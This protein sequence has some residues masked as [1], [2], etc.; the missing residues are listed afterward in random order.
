MPVARSASAE[1]LDAF[2]DPASAGPGPTERDV[3]V[4]L[5]NGNVIRRRYDLAGRLRLELRPDGTW[6][7]YRYDSEGHPR[8]VEHSS[9]ERVDYAVLD[10]GRT[11]RA[12]SAAACTTVQ[13][14]DDGMP[15]AVEQVID[16]VVL[17][18]EYERDERGQVRAWRYPEGNEWLRLVPEG[19][20]RLGLR[21]GDV[22]Y[23]TVEGL[24]DRSSAT[25]AW[26]NGA[27]TVEEMDG[28]APDRVSRIAV[29]GNG[30]AWL[31]SEAEYDTEGRLRR[32]EGEVV[33][34]DEEGR[35][36]RCGEHWFAYDERGRLVRRS[37][38]AGATT[39]G[40]DEQPMVAERHDPDGSV[41]FR[42][43]ALGRRIATES[44]AGVTTYRYDLF[45]QLTEVHLTDG[46]SIRY[47]YDGFGRLVG[48]D[49]GDTVRCWLVGVDG[50]R[51]AEADR[52]GA[53]VASW[54]WIGESCGARID[55]P[56][57]KPIS[58]TYH[59]GVDGR[60]IATA[61]EDGRLVEHD[62]LDPFGHGAVPDGAPGFDG[63]FGDA[64][65]GLVLA[66]T[67]WLDPSVAQMLTPDPWFG[68]DAASR[69]PAA[70][71][72]VV[73]TLP[74][75]TAVELTP[76]A[77][78]AWCGYDPLART[79]PNGHNWLGLIFSTIS[80]LLWEM[81]LTSLSLQIQVVNLIAEVIQLVILR[82]VWDSS[83]YW[84]HSIFNMAAPMASYR[85]M[86]PFA[87]PLNGLLRFNDRGYTIGSVIWVRGDKWGDLASESQRTLLHC[88]E[89]S[90]FTAARTEAAADVFRARNPNAVLSGT[91][92]ASDQR[93]IDGASV[94]NP[95][96]ATTAQV[97]DTGD[98]VAVAPAGATADQPPD[99]LRSVSSVAASSILVDPALPASMGGQAVE[100]RRLDPA[101]V[102]LVRSQK[103]LA[104]TVTFVRG[105]AVHFRNQVAGDFF[106]GE[107]LEVTELL[108]AGRRNAVTASLPIEHPLLR[109]PSAGD[110][111][112]FSAGDVVRIE[113]AGT[114]AARTIAGPG[115][116]GELVLDSPLP[117]GSYTN[118]AV[119]RL[120]PSG[121]AATGQSATGARVTLGP[122]FALVRRDGLAIENTGGSPVTTERGIAAEVVLDLTVDAL[123]TD[124]HGATGSAELLDLDVSVRASATVSGPS[125][126]AASGAGI[127]SLAAGDPVNIQPSS[128]G[129]AVGVLAM[130]DAAA[131]T[132]T[133]VDPL[134]A[135][136]AAGTA[137]TV[138][139]LGG[140]GASGTFTT[141]TIAAPG[142]HVLVR[143]PESAVVA[144][145]RALRIRR[146]GVTTGGAVRLVSAAPQ[147][148]ADLD[149][150]VPA[151]HT[152]NL[153]VT[154]LAP[155]P[156]ASR[157]G[158][159]APAV[160]LRLVTTSPAPFTV[161]DVLHLAD[162]TN[163]A[164]RG[165]EAVAEVASVSG[166]TVTLT[167]PVDAPV[168]TS[169][170]A[171]VVVATGG[172]S[173]SGRLGEGKVLV[174]SDLSVEPRTRREAFEDHEMRH[175]WQGAV[176]GPFLVS[177]PIPWLVNLGFSFSSIASSAS[178]IVR[179]CGMGGLDSL[180]AALVWWIGGAEGATK[181]DG[182]LDTDRRS[183]R[184]DEDAP[185]P[186]VAEF[187]EG[188]RID[189]VKGD[190]AAV[191]NVVDSASAGA[192][193]LRFAL[194]DGFSGGDRVQLTVEPYEQVRKTIS[195][196]FSLNLEQLW[197]DHIPTSWGRALSNLLNRDAWFPLIGIYPLSLLVAGFNED[198]LPNE[199]DAAYH[200]GDLYTTIVTSTPAS[201]FVGQF[202][203][204]YAFIHAR[205]GFLSSRGPLSQLSVMLP[206]G[207]T[208]ADVAGSVPIGS[209]SV[210]FRERWLLPMHDEAEN[211]VGALFAA[212]APG[213]YQLR[214][215]GDLP[216]G[217]DIVFKFAYDVSFLDTAAVEVRALELQP[218]PAR[219][220]L[221]T[222]QVTFAVTGDPSA[223]YALAV[224]PGA[225]PLA[226][227]LSGLRYTAPVLT[228]TSP[229][230]ETV[231]V[232]AT[233]RADH[234]V[235][236]GPGQSTAAN[237][238]PE[239]RTNRCQTVTLRV[240]PIVL[241]SVAAVAAGASSEITLPIAP[242]AASIRPLPAGA[243]PPATVTVLAG[244]PPRIRF[245][246]PPAVASPV[247][248]EIELV[249]GADPAVRKTMVLVVRVTA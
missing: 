101:V 163:V 114:A 224:P 186:A 105:T 247:D 100:V 195:T 241:P 144:A 1:V 75:G 204:I 59:R 57:G 36:R 87:L 15:S 198:R 60:P 120:T 137:V 115:R 209:T 156:A 229:L 202:S 67:R 85:L 128:G 160:R 140:A 157:S 159:R 116:A 6:L 149:H 176:W 80:A 12:S 61:G 82:P 141:E 26:A 30:G 208:A 3:E 217:T 107:P 24:A 181:V 38:G 31:D 29:Q 219:P 23:A 52:N 201:A 185:A 166:S 21:C 242:A 104:R 151:S 58:A 78:Y 66:G 109:F 81:Q 84:A 212:S 182:V 154:R 147:V 11:W 28:A 162:G 110:A 248:V 64:A 134:P 215:P 18:M 122:G 89:A 4:R 246:A 187:T 25:L 178:R 40:Y 194:E 231:D 88:P 171:Q 106:D 86:V 27:T 8:S 56:M 197:H 184:I 130:A 240:E 5:P 148:L 196:W 249:F 55:G 232:T 76:V 48:R 161:G 79:D 146:G 83:G 49:D 93:R 169:V 155:D 189:V 153:S 158:A 225:A 9:G 69:V 70:L 131:G 173:A 193:R 172:R 17:A 203:R 92:G 222:Q 43:D 54:V 218:D 108:P 98:W 102:Q 233:Y 226:G 228:G 103:S 68:E 123:P 45:G 168:A 167:A 46:R 213:R 127:G 51:L 164:N 41:R 73:D 33:D 223:S 175:V 125:A 214:A 139:R 142:D 174:P 129:A 237:L 190:R 42:Y 65:T 133:L 117:T 135:S 97:L 230:N 13:L 152:T 16:G 22:A 7:R 14:S 143:V 220:L 2:L 145:G 132:M 96:G 205:G 112:A 191:F 32:L 138:T 124:L 118:V 37:F 206:T 39:L 44:P 47:R 35:I 34:Y 77:A 183:V 150:A 119:D 170:E 113:S 20:G 177:L 243:T 165:Q 210:R 235:F 94:T 121:G 91:V 95:S 192:V 238:L 90:S 72:R 221:E 111:S 179:H 53:V 239:Q 199:Q 244:D 200:S 245:L 188:S 236:N 234:P 207:T 99:Q 50:H 74:G 62:A 126:L 10:G 227:R 19:A 211:V 216:P 63:L 180:F 136:L 71:R